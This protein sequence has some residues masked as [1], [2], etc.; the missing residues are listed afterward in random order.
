MKGVLRGR[1]DRCRS[2]GAL[3]QLNRTR[4]KG[5]ILMRALLMIRNTGL[6]RGPQRGMSDDS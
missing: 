3:L 2:R 1:D 4:D 5:D 6:E